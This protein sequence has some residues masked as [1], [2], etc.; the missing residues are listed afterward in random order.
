MGT[1]DRPRPDTPLRY[2]HRLFAVALVLLAPGA[3]AF[4]PPAELVIT[5][6]DN[7]PPYL[8]RSEDGRPNGII[9]DKWLLWQE[10][11]G[12]PVRIMGTTW[13]RAQELVRAGRADVLEV[14]ALTPGREKLYEFSPAYTVT[15]SRIYFHDSITGITNDVASLRGFT[16][17]AKDGSACGRWLAETEQVAIRNY[18]TSEAVVAVGLR[19]RDG[20]FA[21]ISCSGRV[22]FPR[23]ER[24]FLDLPR[25]GQAYSPPTEDAARKAVVCAP[26]A[27]QTQK[28]ATP[29]ATPAA[30]PDAHE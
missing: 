6:D 7:Y 12:V 19:A 24:E 15:D 25:I 17:G 22:E 18:A 9:I 13:A 1:V 5:T 23:R 20:S 16:V 27:N 3:Q 11:T 26:A 8:F 28:A 10:K 4:D 2:L 29:V 21:K 30:K 14:V